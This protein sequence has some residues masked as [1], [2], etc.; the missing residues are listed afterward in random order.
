MLPRARDACTRQGGS[1]YSA[2]GRSEGMLIPIHGVTWR[3]RP[4]AWPSQAKLAAP[5]MAEPHR[6]RLLGMGMGATVHV[7]PPTSA[8][9]KTLLLLWSTAGWPWPSHC[10]APRHA[11]CIGS[12]CP[13]ALAPRTDRRRK[14]A[15]RGRQRC[16][17]VGT[18]SNVTCAKADCVWLQN[19]AQWRS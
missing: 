1:A 16:Q 10:T 11:R 4:G 8:T 5:L 18:A 19:A 15:E 7:R 9:C 17:R 13:A 14:K 2:N 3:Q 12:R 6:Q